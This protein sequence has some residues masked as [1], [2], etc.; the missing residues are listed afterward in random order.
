MFDVIE[1]LKE[2]EDE[3]RW[4]EARQ[5][6]LRKWLTQKDNLSLLLRVETECWI[7]MS[8]WDFC[9]DKDIASY[10]VFKQTLNE[11]FRYG[12]ARFFSKGD[13][14]CITGYMITLFPYL[15]Y[16]DNSDDLFIAWENIGKKMLKRANELYP[17]NPLYNVLYLG[18]THNI[19]EYKK[20]KQT[21]TPMIS[22]FFPG[23]TTIEQYF[24]DVLSIR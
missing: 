20:A 3:E 5:L 14:L 4:E 18:T 8:N 16:E 6:L 24:K 12:C 17:Q 19:L 9:A 2:L 1:G 7:V 15:F 21:L 22:T 11:A 10:D 23:E 13:F